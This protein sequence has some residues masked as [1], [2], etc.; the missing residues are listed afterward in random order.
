[1]P[2]LPEVECIVRDLRSCVAGKEIVGV[3]FFFTRML[4]KITPQ[5]FAGQLCGRII[6]QVKRRGKYIL[7]FLEDNLGDRKILEVHLRMTGRFLFCAAPA[8][9]EKHTGAVFYL[10]QNAQLHFQDIRKFATFR[11]WEEKELKTALPFCL[12][13]DLLED[14]FPLEPFLKIV[15][16]KPKSNIKAFLLDQR[17]FMGLGN[18]YA[19][20]AL[21]KGGIH[22]CRKV[23]ELNPEEIKRLYEAIFSVLQEAIAFRGTS[24]SDYRQLSGR[25]GEFQNRL[26]V[27]RRDGLPCPR[28]GGTIVR[29]IVAGRGTYLCPQCQL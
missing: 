7:F 1:M 3:K 13:P 29:E 12:G 22:P 23:S 8:E 26:K 20:E 17:N 25:P 27:Y 21:F 18:I 10:S 6:R 16:K 5:E 15:E 2:E 9:P 28:C 4:G 11:L 14:T 24:F 19:D